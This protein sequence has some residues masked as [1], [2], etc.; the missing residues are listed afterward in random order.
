MS[1]N[2]VEQHDRYCWSWSPRIS[3]TPFGCTRYLAPSIVYLTRQR[4]D[5]AVCNEKSDRSVAQSIV[6]NFRGARKWSIVFLPIWSHWF[7]VLVA[8]VQIWQIGKFPSNC[9]YSTQPDFLAAIQ[10]RRE[11]E[12]E[13]RSFSDRWANDK[14]AVKL[15]DMYFRGISGGFMR[16]ISQLFLGDVGSLVKVAADVLWRNQSFSSLLTVRAGDDSVRQ[17]WPS[18]VAWTH[19]GWLDD[20]GSES[21]WLIADDSADT[22]SLGYA[23]ISPEPEGE[24]EHRKHRRSPDCALWVFGHFLFGWNLYTHA[25]VDRDRVDSCLKIDD[26]IGQWAVGEHW[27]MDET[28]ESEENIVLKQTV[29]QAGVPSPSPP[30]FLLGQNLDG[31]LYDWCTAYRHR[32]SLSLSSYLRDGHI[33]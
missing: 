11:R 33:D 9:C 17:A 8:S 32:S 20:V 19:V 25:P 27:T 21:L 10:S 6:G 7:P 12:S 29:R 26:R 24:Q 28:L 4:L 3:F 22:S 5:V 13:V 1:I 23:W 14:Q 30:T 16:R 18:C 31:F 2:Q 15:C